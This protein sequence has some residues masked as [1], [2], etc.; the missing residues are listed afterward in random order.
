[1][2]AKKFKSFV[3]DLFENINSSNSK[4]LSSQCCS[5]INS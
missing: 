3:F 5:L 4:E 2:T 1:M